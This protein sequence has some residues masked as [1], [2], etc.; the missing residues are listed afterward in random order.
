[1]TDV[2]RIPFN[3]PLLLGP[4]FAAMEAVMASGEMAGNGPYTHAC[5]A[6]LREYSV[7]LVPS[8]TN[9][10]EM[11]AMLLNIEPGD[12][13]IMP[14]WTFVS[15]ANAFVL[16]GGRPVFIDICPDTGNLD[17]R[18]IEAAITGKTRAIVPVHYGGFACDMDTIM[19]IAGQYGLWVI[20]DAAQALMS[21]WKGRALGSIGHLGTFSF[22]ATKNFTS[23]GEGGA[24]LIND[25][26][27]L[28]RAEIIR[29]KGTD[30]SAFLRGEASVY[31]WQDIGSSYL[32]SECQAAALLVQLEAAGE[33][34]RRRR[35]IWDRYQE[36]LLVDCQINDVS[37]LNVPD[38]CSHNA[39]MFA[40]RT[41]NLQTRIKL[42]EWLEAEGVVSATH[43][44]PLHS[45][46][47]GRRYGNAIGSLHQTDAMAG[48]LLRLPLYYSLTDAE[49]DRVIKAVMLGLEKI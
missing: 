24:L 3:R 23:A 6:W 4:E 9:A 20:E 43:Y 12:E 26:V 48:C 2:C 14:S 42:Q 38:G 30:R 8:C 25:P 5:E 11:A 7:L 17:P 31:E 41:A 40:V 15:T 49:Q 10:L 45:A 29:E 13:V 32:L 18:L 35:L 34:T 27:L 47:A 22:H 37:V 44:V 46:P 1:M 28:A 39:H 21:T 16:R 19:D 36:S 33:I